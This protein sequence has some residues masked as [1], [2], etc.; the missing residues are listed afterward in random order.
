[1]RSCLGF[2]LA[3]F[4]GCQGLVAQLQIVLLFWLS[5]PLKH[6]RVWSVDTDLNCGTPMLFI[7]TGTNGYIIRKKAYLLFPKFKIGNWE[8][9]WSQV[10]FLNTKTLANQF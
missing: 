1:M 3:L 8:R 7:R 5:F 2:G 4:R 10:T 9:D 6:V